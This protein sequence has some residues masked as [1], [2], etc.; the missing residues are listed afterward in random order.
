[1]KRHRYETA[2]IERNVT[3]YYPIETENL[4]GSDEKGFSLIL[5]G[6]DGMLYK[7]VY[8]FSGYRVHLVSK[9]PYEPPP[10]ITDSQ[11]R[12]HEPVVTQA[13]NQ[14]GWFDGLKELRK[15]WFSR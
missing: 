14:H 3:G 9:A 1:I 5:T 12:I 6:K 11:T 15:R 7:Q 4:P 2:Y 13:A 8:G 10:S